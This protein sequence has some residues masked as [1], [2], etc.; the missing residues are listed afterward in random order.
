MIQ[1]QDGSGLLMLLTQF[2]YLVELFVPK[3]LGITR[4]TK[5]E[6]KAHNTSYTKVRRP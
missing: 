5:E 2:E 6:A 4:I 3:N 1:N